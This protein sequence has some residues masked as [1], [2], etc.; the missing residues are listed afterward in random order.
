MEIE[1]FR[2]NGNSRLIV[3]KFNREIMSIIK[4]IYMTNYLYGHYGHTSPFD[5]RFIFVSFIDHFKNMIAWY[6]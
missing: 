5:T 1:I 3:M 4:K 2:M 6:H